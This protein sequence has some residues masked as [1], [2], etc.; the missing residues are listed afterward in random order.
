MVKQINGEI[1]L[2]LC[3]DDIWPRMQQDTNH[4][5]MEQQRRRHG[6]K[7]IEIEQPSLININQTSDGDALIK[8]ITSIINKLFPIYRDDS[9]QNLALFGLGLTFF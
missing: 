9:S 7:T 3:T 1:Y 5:I 6:T 4:V 2:A 8:Y